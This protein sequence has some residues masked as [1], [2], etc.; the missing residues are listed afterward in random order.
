ML[1]SMGSYQ[2]HDAITG[3]AKQAVA[4]DYSLL[5]SK[6][7]DKSNVVFEKYVADYTE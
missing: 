7:M 5:L 2:H 4:D 6:S 3:T 1:D